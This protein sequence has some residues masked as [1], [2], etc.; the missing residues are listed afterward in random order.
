MANEK[1]CPSCGQSCTE[2][3]L[4]QGKRTA[5]A[6]T[7]QAKSSEPTTVRIVRPGH[8]FRKGKGGQAIEVPNR[9][10]EHRSTLLATMSVEEWREMKAAA[11]R[12]ANPEPEGPSSVEIAREMRERVS[13]SVNASKRA[14]A[15]ADKPAAQ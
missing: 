13:K 1:T 2:E 3:Q 4:E 12:R 9:L 8:L 6:A 15:A 11:A 7:S 5:I 10:L 14:A